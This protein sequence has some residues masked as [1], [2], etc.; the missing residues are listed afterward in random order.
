M[1]PFCSVPSFSD[2]LTPGEVRHMK[3]TYACFHS[4]LS[5]GST[6]FALVYASDWACIMSSKP[7]GALLTIQQVLKNDEGPDGAD[8]DAVRGSWQRYDVQ[9]ESTLST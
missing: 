5:S 8:L 9:G 6:L 4:I 2:M 1:D 7:R 3:M